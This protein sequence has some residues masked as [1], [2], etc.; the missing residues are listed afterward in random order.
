[1]SNNN[2]PIEQLDRYLVESRVFGRVAQ[3]R[4]RT[5]GC[6]AFHFNNAQDNGGTPLVYASQVAS[7][8]G[9]DFVPVRDVLNKLAEYDVLLTTVEDQAFANNRGVRRYYVPNTATEI[10][11]HAFKLMQDSFAVCTPTPKSQTGIV[12]A[13][14]A[15][16][17]S[18][19]ARVGEVAALTLH[20]F[21]TIGSFMNQSASSPNALR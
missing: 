8:T 5:L 11:A 7:C 17:A 2:Y 1:M 13:D 10:G 9:Q 20:D 3:G 14:P 4:R 16:F 19:T 12:S 18:E 21:P 15:P 6:V